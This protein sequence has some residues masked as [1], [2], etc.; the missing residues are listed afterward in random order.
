MGDCQLGRRP[1]VFA[2]RFPRDFMMPEPHHTPAPS[3]ADRGLLVTLLRGLRRRC[4]R[5]GKGHLFAGYLKL[6]PAC[7]VCGT[8]L[9]HIRADDAPPYF[10]IVIVGHIVVPLLLLVEQLTSLPLWMPMSGAL[11]LT[12]G[13]TLLFLPRVKGAVAGYMWRLGLRGDEYQ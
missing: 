13:L 1:I 9:G 8:G 11:A 2:H 4:P 7:G 10:T 3:K 6:A 12:L 5:C